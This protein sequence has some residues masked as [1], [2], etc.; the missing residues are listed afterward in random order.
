MIFRCNSSRYP[1]VTHCTMKHPSY[2]FVLLFI[3]SLS[4]SAQQNEVDSLRIFLLTA[5]DTARVKALNNL[6]SKIMHSAPL[7]AEKLIQES[8]DLGKSNKFPKGLVNSYKLMGDCFVARSEY[9]TAIDW[10]KTSLEL[11]NQSVINDPYYY[12][13]VYNSL[14]TAYFRQENYKLALDCFLQCLELAEKANNKMG[15][16]RLLNNIGLVYHQQGEYDRSM[17]YF[18]KCFKDAEASGLTELV[19]VVANNLGLAYRAKENYE[20]A[21]KYF[22]LSLDIRQNTN[23]DLGAS[24]VLSN[25]AEIYKRQR[26]YDKALEYLARA[27]ALKER[28]DDKSG[29]VTVADIRSEIYIEQGKLKDAEKL[30]DHNF[31]A[32][33]RIGGENV[34]FIYQRYHDLYVAKNDYKN[35]LY[36]YKRKTGYNDTI[37]N[38]TKS[39]QLAELQTLYEVNKKEKEIVELEKEKEEARFIG[40]IMAISVVSL[41]VVIIL[42][43]YILRLR[44]KKRQ[45][46][47]EMER[48]LNQKEIENAALREEELKNEIEYKNKELASYTINFVQKSELMEELKRNLQT[49]SPENAEVAKKIANI[50]KIVENSYQVDREWEDFK[51]QFE[52]V[53]RDFFRI[54]KGRCPELTNGDLKLCALLKLNM[55]MKEAAKILGISPESV[56]TARYRLRKKFGLSQEANLV[57]FILNLEYGMN[58]SEEIS[59]SA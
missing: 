12:L 46:V 52:N 45:Q 57:D 59:M 28:L 30:I 29:M 27:E 31:K 22:L 37:F 33:R 42:S 24:Q 18:L 48:V 34:S 19:G 6:A 44:I 17:Q 14:G 11:L 9:N 23:N 47:F 51:V 26:E 13:A 40:N 2:Y 32:V 50:N 5:K 43:I 53:H 20:D 54:L 41:T 15:I 55:N 49:I 1:K 39:K 3:I 16:A 56:K 58:A 38:E 35:A 25:L 21:I 7:D 4:G 36:W 10:Y 8:I